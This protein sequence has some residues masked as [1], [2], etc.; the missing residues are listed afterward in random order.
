MSKNKLMLPLLAAAVLM[1]GC[2]NSCSNNVDVAGAATPGTAGDFKANIKDRV[3]FG[4]DKSD[5]TP[6]AARVLE[7]Q[8]AWLKTYP[9]RNATID[10]H[11]DARGT[12]DYNMALTN[13]RADSV[14]KA[15]TGM[16]VDAVRLSTKGHGK[17]QPVVPNAKSE[18]E[19]A[20]NRTAI[21]TING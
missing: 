20:Q 6:A 12:A 2:E 4:F 9:E 8:A 21:T 1:T 18:A 10:A 5:V 15:L 7:L 19:H 16:G 14:K 13:H 11:A 17:D 3:F